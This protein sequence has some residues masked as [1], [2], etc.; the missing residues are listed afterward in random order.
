MLCL[1]LKRNA[2]CSYCHPLSL[3]P[4]SSPYS[5]HIPHFL[6][7]QLVIQSLMFLYVLSLQSLPAQPSA[8]LRNASWKCEQKLN[9]KFSLCPWKLVSDRGKEQTRETI[10]WLLFLSVIASYLVPSSL[11]AVILPS[12]DADQMESWKMKGATDEG[13]GKGE[14]KPKKADRLEKM[15]RPVYGWKLR[16]FKLHKT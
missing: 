2:L 16:P 9:P 1:H 3:H 6:F 8:E 10:K 14:E 15:F 7:V 11:C 12:T 4:R 5:Q 13:K